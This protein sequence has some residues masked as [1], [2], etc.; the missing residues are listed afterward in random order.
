MLDFYNKKVLIIG[1]APYSA[2]LSDFD[3]VVDVN[4]H[5][6]EIPNK[7][8]SDEFPEVPGEERKMYLRVDAELIFI[9]NRHQYKGVNPYGVEY[10][11]ANIFRKSFK[12]NINPLMGSFA[13]EFFR[14]RCVAEILVDGMDLYH[15]GQKCEFSDY[16]S[17]SHDIRLDIEYLQRVK[18]LDARV[19]Y[20][21]ELNRVLGLY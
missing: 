12:K 9:G 6:P 10:E 14:S 17:G 11:W 4:C 16:L 21:D 15:E 18:R 3:F 5:H 20:S 19:V 7:F 13:I 2:D 1:G 8:L